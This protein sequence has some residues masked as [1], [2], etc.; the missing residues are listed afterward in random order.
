MSF[1]SRL[2]FRCEAAFRLLHLNAEKWHI[3]R[4]RS[5]SVPAFFWRF[6]C[7]SGLALS[8]IGAEATIGQEPVVLT[9]H[10]GPILMGRFTGQRLVTASSDQTAKVWQHDGTLVRSYEG[11][12]GPLFCLAVSGNGRV[13]VTGA[14]DNTA[15]VW[16]IPTQSALAS[17]AV[18]PQNASALGLSPDGRLLATVGASKQV[19]LWDAGPFQTGDEKQIQDGGQRR[20]GHSGAVT[21]VT[22]RA[23]S[24]VIAS[25]DSDGNILAWSAALPGIQGQVKST[26]VTSLLFRSNN[27]ELITQHVDGHLRTWKLPLPKPGAEAAMPVKEFAILADMPNV[28]LAGNMA[29][30]NGASQVAVGTSDGEVWL[31]ETAN[32]QI[33]K[34]L[35]GL[36]TPP[37]AIAVRADNQRVAAGGADGRVLIWNPTGSEMIEELSVDGA[38]VAMDWSAD[39]RRLAVA[40]GAGVLTIFGR[41]DPAQTPAAG[42]EL[43][44]HQRIES[45]TVISDV[46]FDPDNRRIWTTDNAGKLSVWAY[47]SPVQLRQLAHSGAVYGADM[48][49]D[50]SLLVTCG[51][52]RS[53][54]IW[55]ATTGQQKFSMSGHTAAVHAVALSP[56]ESLVVSSGADGTIRLWD[57]TGGRQLKQLANFSE[58]MYAVAF[59]PQGKTVAVAGADRQVHLIDVLTGTVQK[60]LEG[61]TDYIHCVR[62]NPTGQRLLSYGYAAELKIW[63]VASGKQLWGEQIGRIGNFA[64]Y[65]AQGK[66]VLLSNGDA[67]STVLP[68]PPAAQ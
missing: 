49:D 39:N 14:Q 24:T 55:D 44:E 3:A 56:D 18:D 42:D 23:D 22:F 59:H 43:A 29:S 62:F 4:Q 64:D 66:R 52:D 11:H 35:L 20:T 31:V 51:A 9:G 21:D 30:I 10:E 41:P 25:A 57:V 7:V 19:G 32:G 61:H 28:R 16:D 67:T 2:S 48:N 34:K 17:I 8:G 58:T 63:D 54:R 12:T 27:Q 53:V 37:Q 36:E 6:V 13:L 38:V 50:G 1:R 60:T 40:T 26:A 46:R 47:A 5:S 33:T 65:D 68:L 45:T 15:R